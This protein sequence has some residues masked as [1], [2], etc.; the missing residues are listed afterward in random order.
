MSL[1]SMPFVDSGVDTALH[2][3]AAVVLIGDHR[4]S[5]LW[6]LANS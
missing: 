4:G 5:R 2:I 1:I 6:I 3:V